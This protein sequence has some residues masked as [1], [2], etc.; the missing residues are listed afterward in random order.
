MLESKRELGQFRNWPVQKEIDWLA[1]QK[2]KG[3]LLNKIVNF[4]VDWSDVSQKWN[5]LIFNISLMWTI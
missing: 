3:Y 4:K 2:G 1:S 5:H